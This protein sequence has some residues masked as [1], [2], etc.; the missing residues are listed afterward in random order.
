MRIA[1][2]DAGSTEARRALSWLSDTPTFYDDLSLWEHL[3][4]IARLHGVRRVAAR[5]PSTCSRPSA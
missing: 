3:E 5:P 1:G 2:H 4:Y